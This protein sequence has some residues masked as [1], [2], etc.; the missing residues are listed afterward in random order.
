VRNKML[1]IFKAMPERENESLA[2]LRL[3]GYGF[4]KIA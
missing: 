3:G 1:E 4:S 2:E